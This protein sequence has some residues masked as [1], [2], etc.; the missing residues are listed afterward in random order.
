MLRET[1]FIGR[2]GHGISRTKYVVRCMALG[3]RVQQHCADAV[4]IFA[5]TMAASLAEPQ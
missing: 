3:S 1:S 5:G 2:L 4:H